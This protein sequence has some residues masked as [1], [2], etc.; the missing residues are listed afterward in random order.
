MAKQIENVLDIYLEEEIKVRERNKNIEIEFT[1]WL[2]FTNQQVKRKLLTVL[3]RNMFDWN[4]LRN[5]KPND[6]IRQNEC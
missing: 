2:G 5:M 1:R 6:W 4:L 3:L